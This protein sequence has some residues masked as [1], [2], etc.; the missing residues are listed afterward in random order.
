MT[1]WILIYWI[2][3]GSAGSY[4]GIHIST[5]TVEFDNETACRSAFTL[6]KATKNY[7][8]GLWGVCVPKSLT[9]KDTTP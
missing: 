2:L 9:P 5:A 6:M 3:S 7:E 8:Q 4:G 1:T